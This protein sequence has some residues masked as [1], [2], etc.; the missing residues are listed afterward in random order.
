MKGGARD[1][2]YD[3]TEVNFNGTNRILG[4]LDKYKQ[5]YHLM[6]AKWTY[7]ESKPKGLGDP[8]HFMKA[9]L[10][11]TWR[12]HPTQR[13]GD[14]GRDLIEYFAGATQGMDRFQDSFALRKPPTGGSDTWALRGSAYGAS[15]PGLPLWP[16]QHKL[17]GLGGADIGIGPVHGLEWVFWAHDSMYL[18]DQMMSVDNGMGGH[19]FWVRDEQATGDDADGPPNMYLKWYWQ[20]K[21]LSAW[22]SE[23]GNK[24][25]VGN[26]RFFPNHQHAANPQKWSLWD[27]PRGPMDS[28]AGAH[29]ARSAYL[30]SGDRRFHD[31]VEQ[32][33]WFHGYMRSSQASDPKSVPATGGVAGDPDHRMG[34]DDDNGNRNFAWP[35]RSFISIAS[36]LADDHPRRTYWRRISQDMA[37]HF[38]E[39]T[40]KTWNGFFS[41][42]GDQ[43]SDDYGNL[44]TQFGGD[45]FLGASIGPGGTP[46]T[47]SVA[48]FDGFKGLYCSMVMALAADWEVCDVIAGLSAQ[49][50]IVKMVTDLPQSGGQWGLLLNMY[51]INGGPGGNSAP[52]TVPEPRIY[53]S[54]DMSQALTE[55]AKSPPAWNGIMYGLGGL[56]V[57]TSPARP[58]FIR[59]HDGTDVGPREV[60]YPK[61][62]FHNLSLQGLA[63]NATEPLK[64]QARDL[65]DFLESQVPLTT[66]TQY[67]PET[68]ETCWGAWSATMPDTVNTEW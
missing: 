28:H 59:Q 23:T 60:N 52:W 34:Y 35:S 31:S 4:T 6:W 8:L 16:M 1:V 13:T 19:P 7:M 47:N 3:V 25:I 68:F 33:A 50:G 54:T 43:K 15:E 51:G 44:P 67:P 48:G 46:L 5:L 20:P 22:G 21:G 42:R 14:G 27:G 49:V 36:I 26:N 65:W 29:S 56:F 9:L 40:T 2:W 10:I 61:Y 53:T 58:R 62:R 30:A 55:F 45:R 63:R 66:Q 17:D 37:D 11:P 41:A 24:I 18:W 57:N 38:T 32:W 12:R 39:N 64:T